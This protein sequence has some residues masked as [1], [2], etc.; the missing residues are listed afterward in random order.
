MQLVFVYFAHSFSKQ[1]I[2]RLSHDDIA[3]LDAAVHKATTTGKE[4]AVSVQHSYQLQNCSL[5][6]S[7][8][9]DYCTFVAW[10]AR[11]YATWHASRRSG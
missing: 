1:H 11:L 6:P 9:N 7:S 10:H 3:E 5:R 8:D 2:F 4:I